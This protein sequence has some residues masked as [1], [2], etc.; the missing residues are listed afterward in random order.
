MFAAVGRAPTISRQPN[1]IDAIAN[2]QAAKMTPTDRSLTSSS[3]VL[4]NSGGG[5]ASRREATVGSSPRPVTSS[6]SQPGAFAWLEEVA[7]GPSDEQVLATVSDTKRVLVDIKAC[8][9]HEDAFDDTGLWRD[10]V[11]RLQEEAAKLTSTTVGVYGEI[12]NGKSSLI[13]AVW[14]MKA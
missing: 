11:E 1:A 6:T 4:R 10:V 2:S 14:A 3:P 8:F 7:N 13:N 9:E 5:A 12:G